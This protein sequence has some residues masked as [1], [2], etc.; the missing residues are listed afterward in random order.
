MSPKGQKC[1]QLRTT[2]AGQHGHKNHTAP[3]LCFTSSILE[4]D[5]G[6]LSYSPTS[7]SLSVPE[8][9]TLS[10]NDGPHS[11]WDYY[12]VLSPWLG[13]PFI[14][15]FFSADGKLCENDAWSRKQEG[16]RHLKR[17]DNREFQQTWFWI[18]FLPCNS[19]VNLNNLLSL[20]LFSYW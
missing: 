14:G 1:P 16:V 20:D 11:A 7:Q 19:C 5:P 3:S 2:A 13:L 10:L 9:H 8:Q 17:V 4:C 6:T 18:L 15:L 12:C